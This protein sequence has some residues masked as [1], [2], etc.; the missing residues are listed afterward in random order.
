MKTLQIAILSLSLLTIMASGAVAPALGEVSQYFADAPALLIQSIVSIPPL[1]IVLTTLFFG[2]LSARFTIRDLTCLGLF[3][4][5]IGGCGAALAPNI[6]FLLLSRAVLGIG[7]GIIMPLSTGLI[8]YFFTREQQV[9]L[10]GRSTAMNNLGGIVA[11]SCSGLLAAISWRYAFSVYGFAIIPLVLCFMYLPN[12]HLAKREAGSS[13]S[14][15]HVVPLYLSIFLGMLILYSFVTNFALIS[16]RE[17]LFDASSIGGIMALQTAMAFFGGMYFKQ[18]QQRLGLFMC[19]VAGLLIAVAF[20]GLAT[21]QSPLLMVGAVAIFGAGWGMLVPLIFVKV[22]SMVDKKQI[23]FVMSRMSAF[24]YA[25]Q[26]AS[27]IIIA[28]SQ[29]ML[30]NTDIRYPF[31]FAVVVSIILTIGLS[32]FMHMTKPAP[33]QGGPQ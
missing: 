29:S 20:A 5:I 7:V 2:K 4:Y 33:Q 18:L 17:D 8:S 19:T 30:G 25:G 28:Q 26:F 32:I 1:C 24:L 21:L 6:Y 9:A 22:S 3:I 10:M 31:Y 15:W 12:E 11:L 27:S 23:A 16:R 14:V 13:T